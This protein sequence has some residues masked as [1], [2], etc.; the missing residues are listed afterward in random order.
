MGYD[1]RFVPALEGGG[2]N[3]CNVLEDTPLPLGADCICGSAY[4]I[5]IPHWIDL[6]GPKNNT[7][8]LRP[9]RS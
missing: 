7:G 5:V 3:W 9:W 6:R 4:H 1:R 2:A 8:Q